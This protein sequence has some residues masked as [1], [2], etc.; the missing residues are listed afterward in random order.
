M[1]PAPHCKQHDYFVPTCI[2]CQFEKRE[3]K[4]RARREKDEL[5]RSLRLVKGKDSMGRT[6][7]E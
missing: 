3:S 7:W 1:K 4:R 2:N 6:L 5:R